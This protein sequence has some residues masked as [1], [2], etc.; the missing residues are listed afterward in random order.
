MRDRNDNRNEQFEISPE[1]IEQELRPVE[2][3]QRQTD[4]ILGEYIDDIKPVKY[5]PENSCSATTRGWLLEHNRIWVKSLRLRF[6]ET[7]KGRPI[8]DLGTT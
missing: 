2:C 5:F 8:K 6:W 1:T 4:I 3:E 7:E